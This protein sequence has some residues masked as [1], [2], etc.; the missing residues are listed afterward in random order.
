MSEKEYSTSERKYPWKKPEYKNNRYAGVSTGVIYLSD[1]KDG[2]LYFFLMGAVYVGFGIAFLIAKIALGIAIVFL[3]AGA[4][5]WLIGLYAYLSHRE[6]KKIEF[7]KQ[8]QREEK[9]R[10]WREKRR[11]ERNAKNKK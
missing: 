7:E 5:L 2:F 8:Q 3:I 9:Q 11:A 6:L 10:L 4:V 1:P